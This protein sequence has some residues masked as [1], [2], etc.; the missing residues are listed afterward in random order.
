[1]GSS[2]A[3]VLLR[4]AI[5]PM[6][7]ETLAAGEAEGWFFIRYGDPDW[8]LRLRFRGAPAS[9]A[10]N[11]LPRL[12]AA[13]EPHHGQ[14]KL[15]KLQL[16]TYER[17]VERYGGDEAM[18][19]GE[20]L[21]Q[22]DSEAVLE[23]LEMLEGDEG[24]DLRWRLA[25]RGVDSLI[26]DFALPQ[27]VADRVLQ[28]MRDNFFREYRGGKGLRVQLDNRFRSDWKGLLPLLDPANDE[29]SDIAPALAVFHRRSER[30]AP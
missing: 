19:L 12:Y 15:W 14:G 7:R 21:F 1:C 16:D 30:L 10:A 24:A 8:H 28:A 11:V 2:T 20:E 26:R 23:I 29:G 6:V 18:A 5:G 9:L 3:D 22:V 4:E 17:E 25:L 27:E 13:L